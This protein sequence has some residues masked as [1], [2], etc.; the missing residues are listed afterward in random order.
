MFGCGQVVVVNEPGMGYAYNG[1]IVGREQNG[2]Y[3]VMASDGTC[4]GHGAQYL[5]SAGWR[6]FS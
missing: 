3:T 1:V 4:Y 2:D 6:A 5:T